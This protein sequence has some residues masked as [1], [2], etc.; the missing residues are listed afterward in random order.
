M[1]GKSL[2]TTLLL[3]LAAACSSDQAGGLL[4]PAS[5]SPSF[6]PAPTFSPEKP[7]E[8]S[9]EASASQGTPTP[10]PRI[11]AALPD[12]LK[13]V[14]IV[15]DSLYLWSSGQTERILMRAAIHRPLVSPDGEW[16][17]FRQTLDTAPWAESI[18]AM[19]ADGSDLQRI[20]G[21]ADLEALVNGGADLFIDDMKW[22]PGRHEL[23]FNTKEITEGPPGERPRF[24]LYVL[25][26]AGNVTRLA[27]AGQ[28]GSFVFSPSGRYL[29]TVNDVRIGLI[30]LESGE[31][32]TLQDVS[33]AR[34][35][36]GHVYAS[37]VAWDPGERFVVALAIPGR[38]ISPDEGDG[39]EQVWR[40][41]IDGTAE[42]MFLRKAYL[43][44]APSLSPNAQFLLYLDTGCSDAQGLLHLHDLAAGEGR[45]LYC[46][47]NVP[48]WAADS[49]HFLFWQDGFWQTGQISATSRRLMEFLSLPTDNLVQVTPQIDWIDNANFLLTLRSRSRNVCTLSIA[50]LEGVAAEIVRTTPESCPEADFS[51]SE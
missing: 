10:I 30:D 43:P 48:W 15:E 13:V 32:Q 26:L 25:D 45:P 38:A 12:G 29:A 24:D 22:M 27:A 31:H 6:A 36:A 40:L 33:D 1:T 4:A 17:I 9:S 23:V 11:E 47:W 8:S 34:I 35:P 50:T 49:D 18:W 21:P 51:L 19:Q 46:V 28:G 16:I 7:S 3:V 14:Y 20:M 5:E 44:H 39:Q 41:A 37:S 2:G 42:M